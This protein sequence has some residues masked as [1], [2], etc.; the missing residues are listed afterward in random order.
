FRKCTDHRR[1]SPTANRYPGSRQQ[2]AAP[3]YPRRYLFPPHLCEHAGGRGRAPPEYR[4]SSRP[5]RKA[6]A[7]STRAA[8]SAEEQPPIGFIVR[9]HGAESG[10]NPVGEKRS[11]ESLSENRC[12]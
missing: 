11:T 7:A 5:R 9:Q 4:R 2:I 8:A 10:G 6:S 3:V 12:A 1:G